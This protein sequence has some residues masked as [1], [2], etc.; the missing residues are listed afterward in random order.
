[1]PDTRWT[2]SQASNYIEENKELKEVEWGPPKIKIT[3]IN[4]QSIY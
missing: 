1:M 3:K 2:V 4:N